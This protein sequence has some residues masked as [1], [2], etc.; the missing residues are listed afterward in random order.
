MK[1]SHIPEERMTGVALEVI[2]GMHIILALNPR[3]L[4]Q[5]YQRLVSPKIS[6]LSKET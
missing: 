2:L 1:F 5:G 3:N 6:F 4:K